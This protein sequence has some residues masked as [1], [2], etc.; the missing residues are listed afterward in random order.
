MIK[1]L[2]LRSPGINCEIETAH[3]FKLVGANPEIVHI[4]AII[5]GKVKFGDYAILAFPGGFSYGDYVAAGRILTMQIKKV[6]GE[7]KKFVKSGRP[8][9]G[10]CNGFQVLAKSGI[11][12][13]SDGK[14]VASFAF[15]DCGHFIG[16]WVKLKINRQSPCIFTRGFPEFIELPIANGEGKFVVSSEKVLSE[17]KNKN[18]AA[19]EYVQNPNGSMLSIAGLC[20]PQ[21]NCF[22]IM[23]HPERYMSPY[24]HYGW[25]RTKSSFAAGLEI[26]RN[27]VMHAR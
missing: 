5:S 13:F 2:I 15:N 27:A 1:V 24:Q 26:F 18:C 6:L 9:I 23:P 14:Q 7:L 8:V 12:P 3:S 19:V 25:T 11:L 10:I 20:N 21:G 17:I 4:N 22:G 16:K